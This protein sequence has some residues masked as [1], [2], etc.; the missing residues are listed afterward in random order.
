MHRAVIFS[1]NLPFLRMFLRTVLRMALRTVLGTVL[2][3]V[4][5]TATGTYTLSFGD[6]FAT[7]RTVL[8]TGR[9]SD[10]LLFGLE[11]VR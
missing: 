8:G 9:S 6:S 1:V 7:L 10:C 3:W 5:V 4:I 11:D 2:L